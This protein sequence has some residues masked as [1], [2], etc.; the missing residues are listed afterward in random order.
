MARWL[1]IPSPYTQWETKV[2]KEEG[3]RW[4]QQSSYSWASFNSCDYIC[5]SFITVWQITLKWNGGKQQP[6]IIAH[7][8]M[9][10]LRSSADLSQALL[11]SA[12]P[13]HVS[14]SAG[15]WLQVMANLDWSW[16]W[17]SDDL[18]WTHW[19]V[20]HCQAVSWGNVGCVSSPSRLA[21]VCSCGGWAEF[22]KREWKYVRSLEA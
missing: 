8:S 6:R 20:C 7:E 4:C 2:K 21:Q 16:E 9:G 17:S 5:I 10:Q 11:I 22:Q 3:R 14:V 15:G 1:E 18:G 19:H 13:T 12:G